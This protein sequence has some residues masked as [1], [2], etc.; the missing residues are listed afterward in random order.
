MNTDLISEFFKIIKRLEK[1]LFDNGIEIPEEV[2]KMIRE[3]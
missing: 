3:L 1:E 2:Q